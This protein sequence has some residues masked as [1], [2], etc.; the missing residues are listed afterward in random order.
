MTDRQV[1]LVTG[2]SGTIGRVIA[3]ELECRPARGHV[4]EAVAHAQA[5]FG[6]V[7]TLVNNAGGAGAMGMPVADGDPLVW[8][9]TLLT[10]VYGPCLFARAV[11]PGMLAAKT[12]RIITVA[13]RAGTA[14][15][16]GAADY[17]VAKTA[18]AR[19]S[20]NLAAETLGT[21]VVAFSLHPGGVASGP[22][23]AAIE[24]GK[25]P[26]D[27]FPDPP[28]AA[29]R[30]VADLADGKH[31]VLSGAYLDIHD[32]LAALTEARAGERRR[33]LRVLDLPDDRHARSFS[34]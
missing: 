1:A 9:D 16:P 28:E 17:V 30:M 22:V 34:E 19:L 7:T 27:R 12:G 13:S 20:E 14:A 8:R 23:E 2:A 25:V 24:Q 26:R 6:P 21:G 5:A 29:A 10:N 31:D 11:L 33:V 3:A 4:P 15:I 18:V 32:D